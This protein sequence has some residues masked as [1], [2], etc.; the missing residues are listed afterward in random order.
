[1]LAVNGIRGRVNGVGIGGVPSVPPVVGVGATVNSEP[2]HDG[3][4]EPV[5]IAH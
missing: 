3:R 1:V 2:G 5:Q 4:P